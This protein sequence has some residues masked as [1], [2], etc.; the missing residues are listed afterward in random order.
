MSYYLVIQFFNIRAMER[1]SMSVLAGLLAVLILT[2]VGC[3]KGNDGD[4]DDT[5]VIGWMGPLSGGAA[6][7]GESIKQG[8]ELAYERNH[9]VSGKNIE[10]VF[11][12]TKC[13]AKEAVTGINKLISSEHVTAIIGEVC[14]DATI[15][16]APIA[17]QNG[18]V[19]IS[20]AS[21]NPDISASGDYIF[22]TVPSDTLQGD[23][24]AKYVYTHGFKRLAVLHGNDSYGNGFKDV[25][26]EKFAGWGGEVVAAEAVEAEAT[27]VRT[28]L[29][30]IKQA[31]P[32]ALYI[33]TNS[34]ETAIS[35][36]KQ[37][38]ELGLN[39]QIFGSE[40]LK[41]NSI[42]NGA[43]GAAEGMIVTAVSGGS[44]N[45]VSDHL[46]KFGAEPGP[47]AAQGYDA[48]MAIIDAIEKGNT[49]SEQ[50]KNYL[51]NISFEGVS[52]N[53][54]FDKNGD[55]AGNYLIFKVTDGLF[56]PVLE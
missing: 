9:Q 11:E 37:A 56:V 25:L 38:K 54:K 26:T 16:A 39:V 50:I 33:I 7:F 15:A 6:A 40:G 24:G 51:Y 14:S 53:I 47:F 2:G 32:D 52:G 36:L 5:I 19:M 44:S 1:K 49:T 55:V 10:V 43:E 8:V 41:E 29:T 17:E 4:H 31:N 22:R 18:V 13:G 12:D 34:P 30:K 28:Q 3:S 45:F 42:V 48:Y 23:F 20:A 21:T 27:D 46:A 35:A